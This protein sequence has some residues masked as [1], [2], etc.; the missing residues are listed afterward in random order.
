M[1]HSRRG[2]MKIG[3]RSVAA[4]GA[5]GAFGR[6]GAMNLMAQ[7][8]DFRALVCIFLFGGNDGNNTIIPTDSTRFQQ[9]TNIRGALAIPEAQLLPVTAATGSTPY[10]LHPALPEVQQ[11]FAQRKLA[12]VSNVGMLAQPLTQS[13]YQQNLGQIPTDLFDHTVQQN[14]W[15]TTTPNSALASSGWGGRVADQMSAL[16]PSTTGFPIACS[17]SG[18][19]VLLNGNAQAAEFSSLTNLTLAALKV[20]PSAALNT[21]FQ[22]IMTFNSGLSLVQAANSQ[23]TS[24]IQIDSVVNTALLGAPAITIPFPNTPLGQQLQQVAQL[25]S[26]RTQLGSRRQIFFCSLGG[27]DT[28]T[29]QIYNQQNALQPLSQAM[30]AFYTATQELGISSQV[31]TF[32]ESEFGRTLQPSS[33]YGSDHGWGSHHMVMGDAVQGGDIYGAFPQLVLGGPNDANARGIWIPTTAVDQY[34]ATLA[35]WFGLPANK[36]NSVFPNL[37]NFATSNLGFV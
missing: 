35:S 4:L 6:F 31:T 24:A 22:Q 18:A 15:Q 12:F 32:T 26:I 16:Y 21:A 20:A 29:G 1:A 37:P 5:T 14:Q 11:L 9:Y 13:Q 8:S 28:H 17:V 36:L 3:C 2:F 25:L 10:G 19:S 7:S 27:F 33:G 34:G 23:T 30:L